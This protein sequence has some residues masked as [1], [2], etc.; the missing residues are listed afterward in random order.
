M[1]LVSLDPSFTRTGICII[2]LQSKQIH[3]YTA[4]CKIGEKQFE[5]VVN[6]GSSVCSQIQEVV[7]NVCGNDFIL[8]MES[9]IPV[10]SMS[11]ALYSLDTI[12]YKTFQEH[13]KQTYN[14][15][16]LSSKIHGHKYTKN[17]SIELAD[18]F[19]KNLSNF[20]YIIISTIGTTKKI[21]HDC[22]EAFLYCW[23]YL[24]TNN[25]KDFSFDNSEEI[26]KYKNRMKNLKAREKLLMTQED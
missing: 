2:D 19:I 23:L 24:H 21:P 9:P 16:T 14:P 22:C 5:N 12:I 6:A 3:F 8:I 1:F 13:V 10:S 7:Y 4:S 17:D 11:A 15:A 25:Y 26:K 20:G 18:K